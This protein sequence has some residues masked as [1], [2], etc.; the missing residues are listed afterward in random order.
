MIENFV[1]DSI[2]GSIVLS[3]FSLRHVF[4]GSMYSR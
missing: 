1:L 4:D 2:N 3:V